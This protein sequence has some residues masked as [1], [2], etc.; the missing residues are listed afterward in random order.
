V[1]LSLTGHVAEE[2][3]QEEN[4]NERSRR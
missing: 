1:F 3:P 2:Q 4:A